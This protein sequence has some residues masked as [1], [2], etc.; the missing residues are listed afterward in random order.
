MPLFLRPKVQKLIAKI[1]SPIGAFGLGMFVTLFLLP[2]T[3]G[4]YIILGG[5][6]SVRGMLPSVPYLLLYNLIFVLPMIAIVIL[7]Y[8]STDKIE[9]INKFREDNIRIIHLIIGILF[10]LLGVTMLTG[11]L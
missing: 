3:V 9:N 7:V 2:C 10:I 5:I 1:T 6:L 4:P 8:F 11:L